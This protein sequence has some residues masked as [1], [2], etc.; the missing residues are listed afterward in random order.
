LISSTPRGCAPTF[1]TMFLTILSPP[2]WVRGMVRWS[3]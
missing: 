2:T 3:C 1:L